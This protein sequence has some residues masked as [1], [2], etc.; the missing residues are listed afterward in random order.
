MQNTKC[1][2]PWLDESKPDYVKY[3][4]EEWGVPVFNDQKMFEYLTLEAAQAGLSWYTV[5]KKRAN[6]RQLFDQFEVSKVA[7]YDD[8]KIEALLQ[9]PGIIRNRLKVQAA[10][11]NAKQFIKI[12]Q[13]FGSFC[14][15]IWAFVDFK[16]INNSLKT[17]TDYPSSSPISDKISKDL[18][19]RGFKFIGSTIIYAYMQACGMVNDHSIDCFRNNEVS[20]IR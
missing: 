1:R 16:P 8:A 7:K 11:N 9:N 2:C 18:K 17:L 10:V 5:L 12:Q 3:H 13:E 14:D 20:Q 19:K 6:Y 4:D 15:Y